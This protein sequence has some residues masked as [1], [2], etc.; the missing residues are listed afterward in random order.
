MPFELT[1]LNA[2]FGEPEPLACV[3]AKLTDLNADIDDVYHCLL[4]YPGGVLANMTVEVISRPHATRELR[5][6]GSEGE[7]VFSADENCVRYAKAGSDG[8]QRVPLQTGVV[9]AGYINPEEP[10]IEEMRLFT[11]A[12][13]RQD[14]SIY[15]SCLLD[16]HRVLQIL[17]RLEELADAGSR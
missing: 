17:Q 2:I 12:L 8:W 13:A 4:R 3:K 6:L 9:E 10:Y 16:D 7:L 5:I 14:K 15:P 11:T 1:W